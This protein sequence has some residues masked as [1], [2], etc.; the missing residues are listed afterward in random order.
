MNGRS[1]EEVWNNFKN[2]ILQC[3]EMFIPH[4]ETLSTAIRMWDL[5]WFS[6]TIHSIKFVGS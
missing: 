4:P 5:P 3:I 1:V 6:W 2:I